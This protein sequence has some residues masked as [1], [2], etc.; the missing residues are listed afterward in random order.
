VDRGA[1]GQQRP[2][3]ARAGSSEQ[4]ADMTTPGV[5]QPVDR[6]INAQMIKYVE[7]CAHTIVQRER[8]LPPRIVTVVG[9]VN[10][11]KPPIDGQPRP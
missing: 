1:N 4:D 9:S 2:A 11:H 7:A 5:T 3:P 10:E 8:N 6:L